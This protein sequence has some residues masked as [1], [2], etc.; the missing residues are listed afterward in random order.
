MVQPFEKLP[1]VKS[2]VSGYTGGNKEKPT[3]EEVSSGTTGHVEA[4]QITFNPGETSYL[5]LLDVFWKQ[6]DPTD[7][8]GSFADRGSQYRSAIFYHNENQK[9]LAEE[10]RNALEKSGR[11][12]KR[13]VTEIREY[14]GFWEAE[15][16]HQNYY[17]KRPVRYKLYRAGSGR[18]QYLKKMWG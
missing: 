12:D 2:I 16:Y 11:Y 8:E 14:T 13:I 5:E 7:E 10:S 17:K 6:I 1:G 9:R 3:Y 15:D 4:V 18:D